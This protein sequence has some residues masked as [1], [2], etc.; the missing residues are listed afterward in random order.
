MSVFPRPTL[1]RTASAAVAACACIAPSTGLAA[2]GAAATV[3]GAVK[4][5]KGMTI[6][7]LAPD[8]TAVRRQLGSG[9]RFSLRLPAGGSGGTT[10]QLMARD[11]TYYG[12]VVLR[13]TRRKAFTTLA[14]RSVKLG[15]VTLRGRWALVSRDAGQAIDVTKVATADAK[16][17]PIGAGKAGFVRSSGV[18]RAAFLAEGA[19]GSRDTTGTGP[20]GGPGAGD[21]PGTDP[22]GDGIPTALDLDAN[23]NLRLD[24]ADATAATPRNGGLFSSLYVPFEDALNANAAGVTTAQIDRLLTSERNFGLTFF[25]DEVGIGSRDVTAGWIDCGRLRYCRAGDGTGVI[26]GLSESSPDLPRGTRWVEYDAAGAGHPN[27]EHFTSH[28]GFQIWGMAFQPRVSTADIRPGDVYN[29]IFRTPSGTISRPTTLNGY[30]VTTPT[31]ASH[32]SG[33]A[34]TTLSY[35]L[36][37]ATPGAGGSP[38]QLET[39]FLTLSVWRPQRQTIDGAEAGD[40]VDMGRL[41]YGVTLDAG[42]RLIG[43][44]GHYSNLSG[45]LTEQ[46]GSREDLA[47]KMFPLI[48]TT[49]DAAPDPART[50]GFTLDLGG[51]LRAE[52]VSIERGAPVNLSLTA[53]GESRPG[54]NDAGTQMLTV[55]LP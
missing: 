18:R 55:R 25:F 53:G 30:F 33:G 17:R 32:S 29:A 23:G 15:L 26:G 42:G 4:G 28:D 41:H 50:V 21:G 24:N 36:D 39:D 16:G 44:G 34:T 1:G 20:G 45:G 52:G 51:C 6:V 54:G 19:P 43:C 11:G 12:P 9:G 2:P 48:D 3:S 10:L 27:L 13:S 35:P 46:E 37:S 14:G 5:G 49:D 40:F 31:I 22:D 38:L 47:R 7:G 8:G